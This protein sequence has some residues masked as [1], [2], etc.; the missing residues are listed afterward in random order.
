[1]KI[2]R[3][4]TKQGEIVHGLVEG[5]FITR[6]EGDPFGEFKSTKT[7][8][9]LSDVTFLVPAECRT[10]YATGLNFAAHG[11]WFFE[12]SGKRVPIPPRPDPGYRAIN[13]LLG[14]EG[15]VLIPYDASDEVHFEGELVAVVGK[16]AKRVS[17]AEALSYVAGFTCGND[18]SERKWQSQ[19]STFWRSKNTDTFKPI[20]P[21]I[22]TDVDSDNLTV[23]TRINGSVVQQYSTSKMIFGA[24]AYVSTLSQYVTLFPG[25]MIFMGTDNATGRMKHGD[26]V[27]VDISD[28]GVLRHRVER[29]HR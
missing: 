12:Y 29:E 1:M 10:L 8:Y 23:T 11:D 24:A 19:D 4:Q 26:V 16:R 28:I 25:D 22:A 27:E 13:A 14:H 17:E 9:G 2:A 15:T 5:N 6:I 21:W 3:V 7:R 18:I 20:G